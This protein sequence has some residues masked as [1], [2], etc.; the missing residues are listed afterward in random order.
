MSGHVFC[1]A[2]SSSAISKSCATVQLDDG[3]LRL[4]GFRSFRAPSVAF[5]V[6]RGSKATRHVHLGRSVRIA[7]RMASAAAVQP[8]VANWAAVGCVRAATAGTRFQ[9]RV[10]WQR[11]PLMRRKHSGPGVRG[12]LFGRPER[13]CCRRHADA[14]GAIVVSVSRQYCFKSSNI[15]QEV[16]RRKASESWYYMTGASRA[17]ADTET[18]MGRVMVVPNGACGPYEHAA[19]TKA[20]AVLPRIHNVVLPNDERNV[21]R[22]GET[23]WWPCSWSGHWT[24]RSTCRRQTA[25]C[26]SRCFG[27]TRAGS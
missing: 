6:C 1:G 8:A 15:S 18:R 20:Q 26:T 16:R 17:R 23:R 14:V 25:A 4:L 22:Q 24:H 5:E 9:P 12:F 21:S 7:P 11:S 19:H 3:N 13:Y 10:R 27:R 2:Q